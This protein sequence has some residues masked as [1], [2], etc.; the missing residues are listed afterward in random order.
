MKSN[1][2]RIGDHIRQV[3]ERNKGLKVK[4]LLG[5]SISK[6]FIPSVANIIGTDMENYKII[7]KNQ[8]AC[9]TMQVRRDKKMPVALLKEVDEAIISQAYPIFEVKDSEE[10]L[11]EYL[12]MW[13]T[14]S[15]FDREA[16]FHAVGGVR[17]SLEWE[18][19]ENMGLPIPP[20]TKQREIVKEYNVIQNRI[21]LNQQLIQ[22]LEET[23]QAIYR[24]WF[25]DFEF[26]D[27]NGK[28]Y[29]SNGGEMVWNEE[30]GK[31]IPK[32]WEVGKLGDVLECN[33]ETLSS[34]DN[35]KSIL[36]LD[37]SNITKNRIN[38]L[39]ELDL[40]YDE[41]PSRA[42]RKVKNND[43]IFSTVRP[44]LKHY[45]IIKNLPDNLIVSTGFAVFRVKELNLFP[46]LVYSFL[47]D[48]KTVNFLQA[49]AEMS[50]STYPSVTSDDIMNLDFAKP[51]DKVLDIAREIFK[52][53]DDF[54]NLKNKE[55]QKLSQLKELLLSRLAKLKN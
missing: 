45:G 32:G 52:S 7:R 17:G 1:Y 4:N 8:F 41:I 2:R 33:P 31:E 37:T 34:N 22:K 49:K 3:D 18:D 29:K 46:E 19:F 35:F 51:N 43:I 24:E 25:V 55:N 27:A 44:M 54:I 47:T 50:V 21:A 36:Y 12:M 42:R 10:L 28:P 13:F 9:S 53:K 15:E 6:Q 38:E 30:M 26:P 39:H 5:L 48:E 20:I 11:P 23:A 14:R 16:C 40:E